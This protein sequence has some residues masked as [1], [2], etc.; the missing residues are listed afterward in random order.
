MKAGIDRAQKLK[1]LRQLNEDRFREEV[2]IPLFKKIPRMRH[3]SDVH[4][5]LEKGIDVAYFEED[6][7]ETENFVG[8]QLK[9]TNIDF[10]EKSESGITALI[11]QA[12]KAF[13]G[14]H[15]LTNPRGEWKIKKYVVITSGHISK[16]AKDHIV[17]ETKYP[18]IDFLDGSE[19]VDLIDKYYIEYFI[20][21]EAVTRD[22]YSM[23]KAK[24]EVVDDLRVFGSRQRR[25]EE[26]F[27]SPTINEVMSE[28][29]DK[30]V[31]LKDLKKPKNWT[32][33]DI[34]SVKGNVLLIG[35]QG[36]G[37]SLLL[38]HLLILQIQENIENPERERVPFHFSIF[39]IFSMQVGAITELLEKI[40][41]TLKGEKLLDDLHSRLLKGECILF[42]DGYNELADLVQKDEFE[43]LMQKFVQEYPAC[44]V[45][46]SMRSVEF[47]VVTKLRNF[48][49]L[50]IQDFSK[51]NVL[52]L[53]RRWY[54]NEDRP[55]DAICEALTKNVILGQLP[56]T[57]LVY[58][59]NLILYEQD[60]D[61]I[62][63]NISELFQK[64]TELYLGKWDKELGIKS[65]F[66]FRI[67]DSFMAAISFIMHARA[68]KYIPRSMFVHEA[69][70]YFSKIG[71]DPEGEDFL[72]EVLNSGLLI[73]H[74]GYLE[75]RFFGLQEYFAGNFIYQNNNQ[76]FILKNYENLHWAQPTIFYAGLK[77]DCSYLMEQLLTRMK[78]I[79]VQ[80][81]LLTP[82]VLLSLITQNADLSRKEVK[83][84][85]IKFCLEGYIRVI[86]LFKELYGAKTGTSGEVL[87]IFGLDRI[88]YMTLGN[89]KL[90][91][92]YFELID[93][94]PEDYSDLW[95]FF[96]VSLLAELAIPGYVEKL[97]D[98]SQ[99]TDLKLILLLGFKVDKLIEQRMPKGEDLDVMKN[100]IRKCRRKLSRN[101]EYAKALI[102]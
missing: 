64:Y 77:R 20:F 22:Y 44:K 102:S 38:R 13:G 89:S 33:S 24:F 6:S 62:A 18:Q 93:A 72:Q 85:A 10:T 96:L 31:R 16:P 19:V 36:S 86:E 1:I 83:V 56:R 76:R 37:K 81:R 8:V 25:I 65:K 74:G 68:L 91:N 69:N 82:T 35:E 26:I 51:Q 41:R 5:V 27:V 45:I 17:E 75:F 43:K 52:D 50:C 28:E 60:K 2:I 59:L 57:P 101:R 71:L 87:I 46:L 40:L 15:K 100:I 4:G 55:L 49:K 14:R 21:K 11:D 53:V 70:R 78:D 90:K 3:V 7:L 54:F 34:L 92:Q 42:V 32:P 29:K 98:L 9:V 39:D 30:T 23:L 95:D 79:T 66:E 12:R 58:T 80:N 47:D 73:D 99:L 48:R 88:I 84:K 63:T 94:K 61:E 67:K 97:R